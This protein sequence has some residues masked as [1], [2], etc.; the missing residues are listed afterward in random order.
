MSGY[1]SVYK[2]DYKEGNSAFVVTVD[3]ERFISRDVFQAEVARVMQYLKS[4]PR[5][6]DV[7]EIL[8]PGEIEF[9]TRTERERNG[10][11]IGEGVW[12]RIRKVAERLEIDLPEQIRRVGA[13]WAICVAAALVGAESIHEGIVMC[14]VTPSAP[15]TPLATPSTSRVR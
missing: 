2:S 9:N 15:E 7:A 14:N 1:G 13:R 3:P 12:G 11:P 4:P 8:I 6:P 10:I 5:Y